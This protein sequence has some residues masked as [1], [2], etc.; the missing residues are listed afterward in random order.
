[1][2]GHDLYKFSPRGEYEIE[3]VCY[4]WPTAPEERINHSERDHTHEPQ[5]H[6]QPIE[7]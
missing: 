1:M 3:G 4:R 7:Q 5:C 2:Q 6:Q